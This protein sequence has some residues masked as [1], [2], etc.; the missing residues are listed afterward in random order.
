MAFSPSKNTTCK[1]ER[2]SVMR[3]SDEKIKYTLIVFFQDIPLFYA[4]VVRKRYANVRERVKKTYTR[5]E[6]Q[7]D[8]MEII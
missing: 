4:C 7:T 2:L 8:V 6:S 5:G 1:N 3:D